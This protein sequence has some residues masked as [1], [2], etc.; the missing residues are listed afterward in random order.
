M[1]LQSNYRFIFSRAAII[2]VQASFISFIFRFV[3]PRFK[4]MASCSLVH[5]FGDHSVPSLHEL[6]SSSLCCGAVHV[7][8]ADASPTHMLHLYCF[9]LL[10]LTLSPPL[11]WPS[12]SQ[13]LSFLFKGNVNTIGFNILDDFLKLFEKRLKPFKHLDAHLTKRNLWNLPHL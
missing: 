13:T 11:P 6:V 8:R 2:F 1:S 10:F 7:R 12:G 3:E 5:H 9:L 4:S